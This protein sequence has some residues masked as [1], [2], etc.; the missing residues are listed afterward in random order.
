MSNMKLDLKAILAARKAASVDPIKKAEEIVEEHGMD[1]AYEAAQEAVASATTQEE[2]AIAQHVADTVENLTVPKPRSLAEIIAAKKAAALAASLTGEPDSILNSTYQAP[3]EQAQATVNE[4]QEGTVD[5]TSKSKQESFA[6]NITLNKKQILAQEMAMAGKSFCLIGPAGCGKTTTQRSV[7]EKLLQDKRLHDTEFKLAGSP[8]YVVAP[9][10][11]FVAYTR[12][13]SANLE[14]A[15]HKLPELEEALVY[16]VMTIHA[17]LEYQP[18]FYWDEDKQKDTMRFEPR[19]HAGNPLTITHLVLEEASMV[20]LDLWEKL[21]DALPSGVQIIFIGDINQLPPVFG[22]SILNYA[23]VQL[24]V[25]ELTEVYR[26]AGDSSIITNAHHILKGE[27]LEP[28]DKDFLIIEGKSQVQVGQTKMALALAKMFQ[29]WYEDGTYDPEQDMILSPFNKQDLGTDALNKWLAQ[30]IGDRREA[31]VHEVVA[32]FSKLYLAVGDRVMYDKQDAIITRITLNG[33]Y[34]GQSPSV[35]SKNLTRFGVY[36]GTIEDH[37]DDP[38]LNYENF[39]LKVLEDDGERKKAASHMVTLE[40]LDS[41]S[42]IELTGAGDFAPAIFS[43]GYALTVHKAQGCEWRHVFFIQHKD[44]NIMN[45]RELI[46]TAVTRARQKLFWI[47]KKQFVQK[48]IDSPRIKGNSIDD[49]IEYFNANQKLD[50][51][52]LACKP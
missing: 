5:A 47:A 42:E 1:K 38:T 9:S 22:P 32:G 39:E 24:P 3:I 45:F 52:V 21:Y 19:R 28:N 12:R 36:R 14:R 23:L 50:Q 30:F 26:Q 35:P 29:K 11:A 44:H 20:G 10:I 41:G 37:L 7:A 34:M 6:L 15:I 51:N 40:L 43:L 27:E 48:G 25:V 4:L 49:K 46:Y 18:I 8:Y 2:A 31:E 16:N 17:L 13:A 33:D